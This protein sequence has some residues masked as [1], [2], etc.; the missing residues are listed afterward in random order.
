MVTT[1]RLGTPRRRWPLVV[2]GVLLLAFLVF[3]G[4]S[5]FVIDVLFFREIGQSDV[6]WTTIRTRVLL[7]VV[8][9]S[10]FTVSLY[11]SLLIARRLRPDVIPVTP[12]QEVLER[13]RDVSDPFLRWLVPAGALVFGAV[14]GFGASAEWSTFLLWRNGADVTF[15]YSEPLFHRDAAFYVF[16]LPW[17]RFVQSWLFSS[18]VG[19]TVLTAIA[20]VL[21][22]GIRPQA[23]AFAD[24]VTPAARAHLS[25]LLGLIMLVKALGYWLGRYALLSSPRGVVEGASYTD[26][27]AQLPALSLLT[28]VAVICALLF[29][30]N[31]RVRQWSLP[32]ISVALLGLV[33]LLVGTA[34]PAF[35]QQFRVKPNEQQL[36]LPY[37]EDNIEATQR[38]FGLDA[39][40]EVPRNVSG[41][42]TAKQLRENRVTL[43]NVRLWRGDPVLK[44][45]F[46]SQQ[47]NRQ[48]Y[49]FTDVDVDRYDVEGRTRV[50]MVSAREISQAG[51]GADGTWQNQHLTY[52]HGYGV[53]AAEVDAAT[54]EGQPFFTLKDLPPVGVPELSQ[55]RIY[56]GE[57]SDVEFVIVGSTE[58]ELDYAEA[59]ENVQY[60]G[61]GGIPIGDLFVRAMFAWQERDFNLLVS[62][63][64]DED[65][66]IMI[67]RDIQTRVTQS[68]PFL[69]P[70]ADPYLA[71]VDGRPT[72]IWDMY[73][74]TD[75]FPYAQS[76]NL[77]EAIGQRDLNVSVNYL[78]N[79]VKAVVDAYDGTITYYA[80]L[81]EPIIAAW[82]RAFPGLFTDIDGAPAALAAHFRYPE[83]LFQV[84][85][86][87]YVKYHVSEPSA[88][89]QQLDFWQVPADPTFG[90]GEEAS[91][92]TPAEPVTRMRPYYQ[93]LRI[94]GEEAESF[95]LVIPFEPVART[96]MVAWMAA[97]SDPGDYGTITVF[98]LPEGRNI[99]GP[100]QVFSR[101]NQDPIF[102]SQRSLLG[103]GGSK[104]LF[105]DFLTI[106]IDDSFLY[107]QPVYV[108]AVQETAVPELKRVVIVNGTSGAVSVG[109]DLSA[110]LAAAVGEDV[111]G[112]E[113]PPDGG[114]GSV[115]E[116]VTELLAQAEE[117]Y[118][119]AQD[120]LEA[121]DLGRYQDEVDAAQAAVAAAQ[122][123][124]APGGSG[125][126]SP[127]PSPS[128]SPTPSPSASASP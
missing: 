34:Y 23:P 57:K 19:I 24:K 49:D 60:A 99:E 10:V 46:Q 28:V 8:F 82:A 107:V 2:G 31:I 93:L 78:R 83:N 80:D 125:D 32:V 65:S 106:P 100:T 21:W 43:D 108:R 30:A 42:L 52:T 115:E 61:E 101:I 79:S 72:W 102:S 91:T 4:I 29:F 1:I 94:P 15:G 27:K 67:R 26:V 86:L 71:V 41:A 56:Y 110:A 73:S 25:V 16:T 75:R 17:L 64:I 127:S 119:A 44:E 113:G 20:H 95:Q 48:Y 9:G 69:L 7:G 123:L 103:Q 63:A 128:G 12:D 45:N 118:A 112:G 59:P 39:I 74:T 104:V 18:L 14:V 85:A 90:V 3:T 36:E 66:R 33:S 55:P 22:G 88:F 76:V 40:D 37:I 89:Y 58:Q 5:G 126:G 97:G 68:V 11:V 105:G 124:L 98:R 114:G 92:A 6:F 47:R 109:S 87:Q 62:D 77:G 117:H 120:A 53:V 122:A 50:L 54:P 81:D 35:V 96:N 13:I 121:G 84:Q 111:G 38:A 70:D 116:Q 51:L